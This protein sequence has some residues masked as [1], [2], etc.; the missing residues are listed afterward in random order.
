MLKRLQMPTRRKIG[1]AAI[2]L[3]ATSD[4]II[5]IIRTIYSINGGPVAFNAIWDILEPSI[6]VIVSALPTYK[7]VLGSSRKQKGTLMYA[8][9]KDSKSTVKDD[10]RTQETDTVNDIELS[11]ST[12]NTSR[13][14][15]LSDT[16]DPF[17]YG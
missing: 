9:M 1:L 17:H 8:N 2:F 3:V 6:A 15:S 11:A 16:V 4:V 14:Q 13:D 12:G 10:T 7:A 5:D